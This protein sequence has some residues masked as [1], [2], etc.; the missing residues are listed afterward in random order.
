MALLAGLTGPAAG[1]RALFALPAAWL[2][3]GQAGYVS[4][5]ALLPAGVTSL[6]LMALGILTAADLQLAPPVV[7]AIAVVLGT[8]HGWMNGAGIAV[9]GREVSGRI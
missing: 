9:A 4:D 8:A 3:G 2:A 5:V 6:S 7:T 1:R